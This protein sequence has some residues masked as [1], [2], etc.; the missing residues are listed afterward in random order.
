[1]VAENKLRF[2]ASS[3][4]NFIYCSLKYY[5]NEIKKIRNPDDTEEEI[6]NKVFGK[7]LHDAVSKIYAQINFNFIRSQNIRNFSNS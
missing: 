4:N 7:I 2:S 6:D 1:M 3:L 5:F